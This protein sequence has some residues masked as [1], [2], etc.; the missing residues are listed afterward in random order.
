MSK[1]I[2]VFSEIESG[3]MALIASKFL[4]LFSGS[5]SDDEGL[6]IADISFFWITFVEETVF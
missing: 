2:V 4:F 3:S 1:L 6:E 5:C